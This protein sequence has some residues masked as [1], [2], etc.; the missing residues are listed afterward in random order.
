VR[1]DLHLEIDIARSA[2]VAQLEGMFDVPEAKRSTV[3]FHFD[4]PLEQ[5]AWQVGLIVGPSGAGK[6]SVARHLFGERLREGYDWTAGKAVV[7]CFG[8]R[9][10]KEIVGALS[11]VGFASPPSWL[12]PYQVL[13]N[14]ERFRVNLARA[15]LDPE[16]LVAIDEFTSVVDR[17]VAR[18]GA[19]ATAKAVRSAPGKQLVAVTCHEDVTDWLQPDW[20]LEPHVGAFSWRSPQRRP[21]VELE[22]VRA[23]RET[24]RWFAPHHY[25]T[26]DLHQNAR[27]FVGLVD[28]QLAA[29]GALLYMPHPVARTIWRLHRLVVLPDFQGLGLGAH[30]FSGA[31]GGIVRASGNRMTVTTSH[32]ALITVWAR[33]SVWKMTVK[34]AFG[35]RQKIPGMTKSRTTKRRVASF[36]YIGPHAADRDLARRLF[37]AS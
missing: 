26:G 15:I 27:C 31:L 8:D 37:Q 32:P 22:V 34:P 3:D 17:Q 21:S 28:G 19:H 20:V 10:I 24:W 30:S 23:V 33:S 9:P 2:R 35:T 14:G 16:P 18:V 13:S 29:F 25:L 1:V 4:V 7:D 36:E 6:S 12:K 5:R 11:A